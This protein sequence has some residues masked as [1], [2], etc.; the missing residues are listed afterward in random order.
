MLKQKELKGCNKC[1]WLTVQTIGTKD[2]I[3]EV[4]YIQSKRREG[5]WYHH[6][7]N[8][9]VRVCEGDESWGMVGVGNHGR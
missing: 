1:L 2:Y 6:E 9:G 7:T 5:K 4:S 3:T 8:G